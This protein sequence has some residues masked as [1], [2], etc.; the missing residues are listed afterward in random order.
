MSTPVRAIWVAVA[1]F[2]RLA[3]PLVAVL[4]IAASLG[5][6]MSQPAMIA[7]RA[8]N[9]AKLT[10]F[11]RRLSCMVRISGEIGQGVCHTGPGRHRRG[12]R[13]AT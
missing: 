10:P 7:A 11:R 1:L 13:H 6:G 8:A 9:L 12:A 2:G 3:V 4:T 5:S